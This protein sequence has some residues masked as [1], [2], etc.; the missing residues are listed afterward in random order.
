M[1]IKKNAGYDFSIYAK[2]ID[3]YTGSL[4]VKI[5]NGKEVAGS[6]TIEKVTSDWKKYELKLDSNVTSNRNVKLQV[7]I[8][9]GKIAVDMVSLFPQDTYKGERMV[10]EKI[11]HKNLKNFIRDF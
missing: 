8:P 6:G 1:S 5:M 9:K 11:L 3:G 2:G 4:N 10:L 7:T